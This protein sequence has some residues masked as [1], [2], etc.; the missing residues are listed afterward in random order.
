MLLIKEISYTHIV[1]QKF[2]QPIW[3]AINKFVFDNFKIQKGK[4][5]RQNTNIYYLNTI[6]QSRNV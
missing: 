1:E 5:W 2:Q 6:S 4:A 3:F